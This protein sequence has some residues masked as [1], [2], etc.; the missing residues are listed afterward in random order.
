[1]L[2]KFYTCLALI[3]IFL[4]SCSKNDDTFEENQDVSP[5]VDD[6]QTY[7]DYYEPPHI[8]YN[9]VEINNRATLD[10]IFASIPDSIDKSVAQ[11]IITTL[12]R[13]ELR[14]IRNGE[15]IIVPEVFTNNILDYSIFPHYYPSASNIDK[16]IIVAIDKQAYGCYENGRLVRFAAVNSG[17]ERTPSFPGRYALVW[18]DRLRRSSLD[19]TWIMPFT[20]NFHSAAGSAFHQFQMPGRPV[21]HS[22]LRQF[23][24]DAQWLFHWGET[25]KKDTSGKLIPF[26]GTPV[27]LLN[28]FDYSRPTGGPW[29]DFTSNKDGIVELPDNP[30]EIEEALIPIIQIPKEARASLTNRERYLYAEDSLR[31]R[32]IIR[33]H[34]K[35]TPS[36]NFNQLRRQNQAKKQQ[37]KIENSNSNNTPIL[38]D[39]ENRDGV[40]D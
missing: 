14:F 7:V 10:S 12:N 5:D 13:K 19:S 9:L 26:S 37:Q 2:H 34:V 33:E 11:K 23:L 24:D 21:S 30:L 18:K 8:K 27:I 38:N 36:I 31:A 22:C 4:V 25:A 3:S 17:K 20:F 39:I 35:L 6:E 32:G 29:L 16:I 28:H 1:M 40:A 15:K